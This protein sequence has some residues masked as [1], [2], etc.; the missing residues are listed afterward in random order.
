M[1]IRLLIV[2][3]I[4]NSSAMRGASFPSSEGSAKASCVAGVCYSHFDWDSHFDSNQSNPH[5]A[6]S[7]Q[8]TKE[9]DE[10]SMPLDEYER[11]MIE[12]GKYL[13]SS[14][15]ALESA[16]AAHMSRFERY[17]D[18]AIMQVLADE[19]IE[20]K[21]SA[22]ETLL[23]ARE[24]LAQRYLLISLYWEQGRLDEA[25]SLLEDIPNSKTLDYRKD[26]EYLDF[27]LCYSI[28]QELA[29]S[30]SKVLSA[31][32]EEQLLIL[33]EKKSNQAA[34]M[35]AIL[36]DTYTVYSY[37]EVLVEPE[38]TRSMR[39]GSFHGSFP[40]KKSLGLFPNPAK[41]NATLMNIPLGTVAIHIRDAQGRTRI[42]QAARNT[43][44][45]VLEVTGLSAGSYQVTCL[46]SAGKE[47]ETV[48]FI[49]Q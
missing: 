6:K 14:K 42:T 47:I 11:Y 32:Q 20:D 30:E 48:S 28:L 17:K 2:L 38:E 33:A 36:L 45:Q 35:A 13:S 24:T 23:G 22:V 10:R 49:V 3:I 1:K 15:E 16:Y 8:V 18:Q 12:Q 46:D 5:A 25:I 27:L 19:S 4:V 31:Y 44:H 41:D 40:S 34:A 37:Y 26:E 43:P 21:I 9:L 39:S 7:T 29:T